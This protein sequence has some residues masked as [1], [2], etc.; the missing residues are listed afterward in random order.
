MGLGLGLD[1]DRAHR[2]G[3]SAESG[4]NSGLDGGGGG[5]GVDSILHEAAA[6]ILPVE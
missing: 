1:L 3:G 6:H 2:E 5:D 4:K